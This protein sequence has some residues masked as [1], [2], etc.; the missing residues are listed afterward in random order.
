MPELTPEKLLDRLARGKAVPAIVLLG[1]DIYLRELCR[2]KIIDVCVPEA[3]RDWALARIPAEGGGWDEVLGR[4]QT[5]PMLSAQ[6]LIVVEGAESLEKLDD[7]T[8]EEIVAALGKYLESPAPFTVLL[9]ETAQLDRR[10]RFFKLLSEKALLVELT[11][12]GESAVSLAVQMA[13][14]LGSEI[15]RDAAALLADILNS[16]PARMHIEIEKLAAYA[17]GRGPIKTA[18]VRTLVVAARKND[19]WQLA[20][21][22]ASRR[23]DSALTFLDNLLREGEEPIAIVGALAW[24]YRKL[25]EARELPEHT[26]G[27]QAARML[28]MRA[29]AAE[30]AVRNAHRVSRTQ[31]VAGLVALGE[32]DSQLKSSHPNP[33]ALM[34]FLITGLTSSS[35]VV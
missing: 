8:R 20:D 24:A 17:R 14:D 15:D 25:I 13:K 32:A 22:L 19:V 3:A 16:E 2:K 28:G 12:G 5:M 26:S 31:L 35:S 1:T 11:I 23:R 21:M 10:Q 4:A 30:S 29:P 6:Q 18:D 27:F 7:D 34:E 33:R 9:I